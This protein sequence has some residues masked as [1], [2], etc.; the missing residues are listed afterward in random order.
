[1]TKQNIFGVLFYTL[2]IFKDYFQKMK[3]TLRGLKAPLILQGTYLEPVSEHFGLPFREPI[4]RR[5]ETSP[6]LFFMFHFSNN[7]NAKPT[8]HLSWITNITLVD[9]YIHKVFGTSAG[10]CYDIIMGKACSSWGYFLVKGWNLCQVYS[11]IYHLCST[12][13]RKIQVT[14]GPCW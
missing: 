5:L 2:H 8:Q 12:L 9:W 7:D 1:M 6:L 4:F 14:C 13:V 10:S 3:G 11:C